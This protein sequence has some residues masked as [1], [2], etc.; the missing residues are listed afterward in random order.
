MAGHR[1]GD[2]EEAAA[3]AAVVAV[4]VEQRRRRL[5]LHHLLLL[6]PRG[7]V[8]LVLWPSQCSKHLAMQ[9]LDGST[10]GGACLIGY[11]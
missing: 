9:I 1:P 10:I 4:V 7:E 6:R 8:I 5:H 2:V 11:V 3:A